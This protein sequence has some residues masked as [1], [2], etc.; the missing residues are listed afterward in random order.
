MTWDRLPAEVRMVILQMY[1]QQVRAAC[2]EACTTIQ[3]YIRGKSTRRIFVEHL[4]EIRTA[5]SMSDHHII[6]M[7]LWHCLRG[8]PAAYTWV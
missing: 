4:A 3:R 7:N 5:R 8:D 6:I 2:I 1:H